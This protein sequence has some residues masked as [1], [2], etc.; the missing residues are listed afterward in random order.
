MPIFDAFPDRIDVRDW[1]YQPSLMP[2]PDKIVN[3]DR[4]PEI[5][6]QKN[7]GA[8]TGFALAAVINFQL[9]ARN[10]VTSNQKERLVSPRML[11]EMARHYD[12][13]PGEDYEGSSARGTMKG[14]IAH[15]VASQLSWPDDCHSS[16][17]LTDTMAKEAQLTPGGAY[18]RV[19]HRNIR[20]MHAALHETGILYATLMVHQGWQ[21]PGPTFKPVDYYENGQAKSIELPVISRQ[22]RAENGHAIAIVGYTF[23]GFIVQNS[24]GTAWGNNGFA[25]L[26]YEDWM[27]HATD[28]WV[29]QLGVPVSINV[30]GELGPNTETYGFQRVGRAIPL[31]EIRPYVIDIGNNGLLS[32]SGEYWTTPDD[33]TRLFQLIEAR[34]QDWQKIRV[35]LYIHGGLNKESDVAKRIVAFRDVC[36]TNQIYPVHVMW[37]TGFVDSLK[38]SVFD[39]FTN[40]DNRAG[41]NW[42]ERLREGLVDAKD[43]SI[44]LTAASPGTGLWDEMKENARLASASKGGMDL[45]C[46]AAQRHLDATPQARKQKWELHLVGHSAGSIFAAYAMKLLTR[47][48]MSIKTVQFMAPA[49]RADLFKTL[50]RTQ[51][52]KG[53]LPQ[54]TLYV[55]SDKA[56]REDKTTSPYGKSLLYLVSNAFERKR[57]TPILGME[58][59]IRADSDLDTFFKKEIDGQP[60]LIIAAPGDNSQAPSPSLSFSHTHGGF[61][62]D[63]YTLNSILFRIL[64]QKPDRIFTERDL[65]Y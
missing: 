58:K 20:D 23:D 52:N 60:S 14:W 9:A 32:N 50:I 48:D 59:F 28:C 4:V 37:E 44:E 64:N 25:L 19:M 7:E 15:G 24:W 17:H 2:L 34:S 26:P 16:T 6:D 43:R 13:W 49:I 65:Q 40:Q 38:A 56:E 62:N 57:E 54:P 22:G 42:F 29:A 33:L 35:M 27:L 39:W 8:C 18:Y 36:L 46:Q 55:L 5:L 61:D 10:L 41:V 63:S 3:C 53:T 31:N 30:W 51:V 45:F 11:Y 21:A 12:E 1:F 47:L